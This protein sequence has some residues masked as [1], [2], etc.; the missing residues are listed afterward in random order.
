MSGEKWGSS[1]GQGVSPAPYAQLSTPAA[2][3]RTDGAFLIMDATHAAAKLL[4]YADTQTL[5]GVSLPTLF[6]DPADFAA[7]HTAVNTTQIEYR[8]Y[9]L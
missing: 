1:L 9:N 3:I 6:P 4:G 8:M 5:I 2:L 7:F